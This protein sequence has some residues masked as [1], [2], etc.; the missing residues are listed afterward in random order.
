MKRNMLMAGMLAA[1]LAFGLVLTGCNPDGGG[2][3]GKK[4][5]AEVK[6]ELKAQYAA[7][8]TEF[9][10][11]LADWVSEGLTLT[12][13]ADPNTWSDSDWS[14]LYAWLD[15]HGFLDEE[16]QPGAI[17]T[18][19]YYR[20]LAGGGGT[21]LELD[22]SGPGTFAYTDSTASVYNITGTYT[23]SSNTLTFTTTQLNGANAGTYGSFTGTLSSGDT[24]LTVFSKTLTLDAGD[25]GH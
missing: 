25:G 5:L 17:N 10:S 14:T 18:S 6:T 13:A 9:A 4:S 7:N 19:K 16:N 8:Q 12:L 20:D 11:M 22:S 24:T 2:G 23:R 21:F 1:V 3:D 15:A